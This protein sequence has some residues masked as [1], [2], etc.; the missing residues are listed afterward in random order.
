MRARGYWFLPP[1]GLNLDYLI[2]FCITILVTETSYMRYLSNPPCAVYCFSHQLPS[3]PFLAAAAAGGVSAKKWM[4][5]IWS[6]I[7]MRSKWWNIW[8]CW[9]QTCL[10]PKRRP[11]KIIAIDYCFWIF[12][13]V[14]LLSEL[15]FTLFGW[16]RIWCVSMLALV[17]NYLNCCMIFR[18]SC[19]IWN[20]ENKILSPK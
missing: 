14:K 18:Y 11:R 4:I 13:F 2:Y 8:G 9:R 20:F 17:A 7:P 6:F 5:I 10:I 12:G 16:S 3:L 19:Q 1:F 15:S